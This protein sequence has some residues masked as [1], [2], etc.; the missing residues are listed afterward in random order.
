MFAHLDQPTA[1]FCSLAS[2]AAACSS[3]ARA[4]AASGPPASSCGHEGRYRCRAAGRRLSRRPSRR[5]ALS[6]E[7]CWTGACAA[8]PHEPAAKLPHTKASQPGWAKL[9]CVARRQHS[10]LP[11]L[12]PDVNRCQRTSSSSD[13]SA[14]AARAARPPARRRRMPACIRFT[15]RG[16]APPG[17]AGACRE[18]GV[19]AKSQEWQGDK[20]HQRT[21]GPAQRT[22]LPTSVGAASPDLRR[23]ALIS[24]TASSANSTAPA[25]SGSMMA[26]GGEQVLGSGRDVQQT[27]GGH[28]FAR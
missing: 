4:R 20:G 17:S 7:A 6:T 10:V 13:P 3:R 5:A 22:S 14:P 24:T 25:S 15:P 19:S 8:L 16:A 26:A 28:C 11:L 12:P 18:C 21:A 1:R 27:A 23:R 9:R 2:C